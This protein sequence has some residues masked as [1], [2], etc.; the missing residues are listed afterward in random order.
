MRSSSDCSTSDDRV[1][2][3]G[4]ITDGLC[5]CSS[6]RSHGRRHDSRRRTPRR[7]C[8]TPSPQPVGGAARSPQPSPSSRLPS[9]QP[10]GPGA[11]VAVA[12]DIVLASWPVQAVQRRPALAPVVALLARRLD[13]PVA[14]DRRLTRHR[15]SR[16][17]RW[18]SLPSSHSS[19]SVMTWLPQLVGVQLESQPSPSN[20]SPSSHCSPVV[21]TPLPQRSSRQS[22]LQPSP[23]AS[24]PSSHS[25]PL[26]RSTTPLPHRLVRAAVRPLQ[27]SPYLV[28][29]VVALEACPDPEEAVA[30][31]PPACSRGCSRRRSIGCRPHTPRRRRRALRRHRSHSP[32][33]RWRPTYRQRRCS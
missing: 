31:A 29:A 3:S 25:S 22:G 21:T 8:A 9:S 2:S 16:R 7:R 11:L 13:D 32:T 23:A 14:A 20:R 15:C 5:G 6:K 28:V 17:Y 19:P 4:E 33:G 26:M 12:A 30:A 24:L 10:L 27:P 18:T 1:A